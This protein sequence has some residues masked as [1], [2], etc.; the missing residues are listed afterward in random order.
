[1]Y[2]KRILLIVF[3]SL[4]LI[5]NLLAHDEFVSFNGIQ[6]STTNDPNQAIKW[7]SYTNLPLWIKFN[8]ENIPYNFSLDDVTEDFEN[9]YGQWQDVENSCVSFISNLSGISIEFTDDEM[10]FL[11]E[12]F[13]PASYPAFVIPNVEQVDFVYRYTF[14]TRLYFNNTMA[15]NGG[16]GWR[17]GLAEEGKFNFT[18]VALHELGHIIGLDHCTAGGSPVMFETIDPMATPRVFLQS[19]DEEGIQLLCTVVGIEDY[20]TINSGPTQVTENSNA[21][22]Y[23]SFHDEFPY[24]DDMD[25]F[26]WEMLIL[27]TDGEYIFDSGQ[28]SINPWVANLGTLPLGY[29]WLR[30]ENENV[31]GKVKVSGTD[32]GGG[33]GGSAYHEAYYQIVVLNIPG[34]TTSGTLSQDETWCGVIDIT[35]SVTIPVGI[36]LDIFNGTTL[37]VD[38]NSSIYVYGTLNIQGVSPDN[39]VGF[40]RSGS[41][42]TWG[43]IIFDGSAASSSII[44]NSVILY[45]SDIQCLNGA[46]VTIQNSI[47]YNCTQGIYIYNSEPQILNNQII[48]PTNNGIYGEA[49]GKQP[50]IQGNKIIRTSSKNYQ[51]I[52]FTN[53]TQPFITHND[54]SG[55]HHAVYLGGGTVSSFTEA[56]V[57]SNP[58]NR[59]RNSR[60]GLTTGWG[61]TTLAGVVSNYGGNNSIYNNSSRDV[62]SYQS[63]TVWALYNYWGGG[64]ANGFADGS[65]YLYTSYWLDNDPWEG[66]SAPISKSGE[67]T[68]LV[69]F[70][71]EL[72]S[73]PT[74]D[75]NSD[76]GDLLAGLILERDGR[77]N[78]A[79][80]HYK[81]MVI[82][83]SFIRPA[84][85]SLAR[86]TNRYDRNDL[87]NYFEQLVIDRAELKVI[88]LR[89]L[90]AMHLNEGNYNE[91]LNIFAE[92][93]LEYEEEYEGVSAIL[94]KLFAVLNYG[95]NIRLASNLFMELES[96]RITD[97]ELLT[98]L[99]FAN[100]LLNGSA[101]L[102]KGTESLSNGNNDNERPKEFA[103]YNN[104]PNP[105]N[106]TTTIEYSIKQDGLVSLKVY[107]VLGNEV[108]SLVNENKVAGNY[109]VQFDASN[110]PSG[111]YIY[112][113]TSGQFTSSKKLILLK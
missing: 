11:D 45:P 47:I 72:G 68:D 24:G 104:Y 61:S 56:G 92:I 62:Y 110:L 52:W 27:H 86:I 36:S 54:V 75:P 13:D 15:F 1:M 26:D 106:P 28:T 82:R 84:L 66:S 55:F 20:I 65:S 46:D 69:Y 22:Y 3:L 73:N 49:S 19:A 78:E 81:Q 50:L 58:N 85:T 14:N 57:T 107:D 42:G 32:D 4:P 25:E 113:L 35:G 33:G 99:E 108:V 10:I 64:A 83:N 105:F 70:N 8:D 59:L 79:V 89:L 74:G 100:Y 94:D 87:F 7:A 112:R 9:A 111:I 97:E 67:V 23:A 91:T 95:K 98:R 76:I 5:I 34:I 6:T 90:A 18:H 12:F 30:D 48:E 88:L 43:S 16:Y 109:S 29:C 31:M 2:I 53:Y 17:R 102:N 38:N 71:P 40:T 93:I 80:L 51:G 37:N 63:S 96:L 44:N 39:M 21:T 41:S 77:I 103:L 60:Y 101:T